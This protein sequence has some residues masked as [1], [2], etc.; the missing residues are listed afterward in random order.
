M[1]LDAKRRK[2]RYDL[3]GARREKGLISKA[4]ADRK[5]K[6]KTADISDLRD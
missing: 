5:K 1:E 6:N 3:D 4:I 2:A